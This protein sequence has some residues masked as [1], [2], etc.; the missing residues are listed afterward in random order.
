MAPLRLSFEKSSF[1]KASGARFSHAAGVVE[2]HLP[3]GKGLAGHVGGDGEQGD[4]Q[5]RAEMMPK[6]FRRAP[7]C[8]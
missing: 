8:C 7:K 6:S 5:F 3:S 4:W 1:R 2:G